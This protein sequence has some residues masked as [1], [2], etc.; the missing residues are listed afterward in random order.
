MNKITYILIG[1]ITF[2]IGFSA[3][4]LRPLMQAVSLCEVSQN[5]EFY[6]SKIIKIKAYLDNAII[7]D[8]EIEEDYFSVSDF[9]NS[10]LTGASLELSEN[11]KSDLKKNE[12]LNAFLKELGRKKRESFEKRNNSGIYIAEI[13]IVGRIEKREKLEE[14]AAL[15][16]PPPFIIKA[17][18]IK[19]ISPVRLL[20][21]EEY[22]TIISLK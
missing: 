12:N 4:T 10:C 5:S 3:Y 21:S 1:F 16:E 6:R 8:E 7:D 2:S 14:T 22:S 19:Q 18:Q 13:E 17:D 9:S 15:F 20:S 11:L